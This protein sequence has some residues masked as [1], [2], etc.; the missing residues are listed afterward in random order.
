MRLRARVIVSYIS[1]DICFPKK[2]TLIDVSVRKNRSRKAFVYLDGSDSRLFKVLRQ[3]LGSEKRAQNALILEGL[4][5]KL[6][7]SGTHAEIQEVKKQYPYIVGV[8]Y[9][10]L[11]KIVYSL[12]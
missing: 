3:R 1:E 10:E 6:K 12:S 11:Q 4:I 8:S 7:E 2:Y 5:E 9:S